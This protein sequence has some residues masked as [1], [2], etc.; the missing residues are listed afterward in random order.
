MGL[1]IVT[2]FSGAGKSRAM[3]ILED[4]G[5]Y[6]VDN[7]P[8]KLIG[9]FLDLWHQQETG[10]NKVALAVDVRSIDFFGDLESAFNELD[11]RGTEYKILFMDCSQEELEKRF[12]LTRRMHPLASYAKGNLKRAVALEKEALAG[13][14]GRADYIIDTS[15]LTAVQLKARIT[16]L[17]LD[18][19][20]GE[21]KVYCQSFGFKHGTD[22]ECSLVFDV[23][24]IPNPYYVEDLREKTGLD[25]EVQ[26]YVMSFDSAKILLSK[27]IDMVDFLYPLYVKE[28]KSQLV[29]GF[30]CSGGK[31]RSVTFAQKVAEHMRELGREVYVTHRDIDK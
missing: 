11:R 4:M 16:D 18:N 2:G 15:F 14:R 1:V 29:I 21:I 19:P 30:G 24:C 28:G 20:S 25:K 13:I 7:L 10:N 22:N 27:V 3:D 23:R 8:P 17:F 6:C 12:N 5:Y 9:K 26:D 31:H